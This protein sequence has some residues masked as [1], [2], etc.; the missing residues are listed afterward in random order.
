MSSLTHLLLHAELALTGPK[1]PSELGGLTNLE[2]LS[3]YDNK[4]DGSIPSALG[5]LSSLEVLYLHGNDL[6]GSRYRV[7]WGT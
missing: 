4:L 6:D 5:D 2:W 7:S 3:L 1:V